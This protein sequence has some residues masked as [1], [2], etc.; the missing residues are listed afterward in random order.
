MRMPSAANTVARRGFSSTRS[1]LA[2][3]YHYPEGP[4]NNIPFNPMTKF[5]AVRYWGFMGKSRR[6]TDLPT[7]ANTSPAVG[8]G[9]PFAIA[10]MLSTLR[11][12][13]LRD[14]YLLTDSLANQEEQIDASDGWDSIG[15]N[16]IHGS[17]YEAA[18]LCTMYILAVNCP[19]IRHLTFPVV[20]AS[21]SA[22]LV[23][24]IS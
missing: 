5:F 14:N 24:N 6:S 16:A 23:C 2:S 11:R 8:F 13:L 12:L 19:G 15:L 18:R 7:P 1:Q 17:T 20:H 21:C 22:G 10:G 3:P 9:A 4:R